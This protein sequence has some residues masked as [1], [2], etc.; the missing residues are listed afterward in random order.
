MFTYFCIMMSILATAIVMASIMEYYNVKAE[1]E[2][3]KKELQKYKRKEE[4]ELIKKSIDI[5]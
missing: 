3:T 1:L 4:L 2:E 5:D